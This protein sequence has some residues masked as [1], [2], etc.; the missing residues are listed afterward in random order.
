VK[1]FRFVNEDLCMVPLNYRNGNL[2][3]PRSGMDA[4]RESKSGSM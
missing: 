3:E 4:G 2:M 1:E